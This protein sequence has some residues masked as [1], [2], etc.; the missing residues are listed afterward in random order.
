MSLKNLEKKRIYSGK[1]YKSHY[2][3]WRNSEEGEVPGFDW[4]W[5]Y[6]YDGQKSFWARTKESP[7]KYKIRLQSEI[8]TIKVEDKEYNKEELLD[9]YNQIANREDENRKNEIPDIILSENLSSHE[10]EELKK[11]KNKTEARKWKS[12]QRSLRKKGKLEQH[13]I[14]MLNKLGMIWHP[15]GVNGSYDKWEDNFF[16]YRKHGLCFDLKKWVK[17]QRV[18]FKENK[19]SNE[20]LF[21][22]QAIDFPFEAKHDEKYKLTTNS[23]WELRKK[24]DKKIRE[25]E[26]KEHKKFG[27]Y[28][29][30]DFYEV[31]K[32]VS[33]TKKEKEETKKRNKEVNSFYNRKYLYCDSLSINKLSQEEALNELS[34]IDKGV[35][36]E[37]KRLEE[38]LDYESEKFNKNN[39]EIPHYIEQFYDEIKEDKLDDEGIYIEL[40]RFV[41]GEFDT[42]IRKRACHY[43]LKYAPYKSL[44]TTKFKEIDFLISIYKKEKNKTELLYLKDLL[45]KFPLLKELYGE[46]LLNVILK[47]K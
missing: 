42:E 36:Y 12:R 31:K 28:E 40:S 41:S 1:K 22:L 3:T 7:E 13:K 34:N 43:M 47:L 46:K 30:K 23:C 29:E 18:L 15:K 45:E 44:K 2:T 5:S 27:I 32:I 14:D 24:L 16:I 11:L 9:I 35:S 38:F 10:L 33:I 6:K 20:N 39:K 8:I 17:E 21:R 25:F 4:E 37:D 26:I 19:I